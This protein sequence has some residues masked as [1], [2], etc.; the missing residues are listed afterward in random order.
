M[1]SRRLI[2]IIVPIY[3]ETENI[4]PIYQAVQKATKKLPY[5][6]E[7]IFVDDGS[8]DDSLQVLGGL[9]D[10]DK[11]VLVIE[12]VRNFGKEIAL[13]AGL[14]ASSGHAAIM[15]D[16]D[17][18]H[19]PEL[20]PEFIEK[21][22]GG[23][24]AVIGVRDGNHGRGWLMSALS[25]LFYKIVNRISDTAIVPNAT[26]FR[27]IDQIIIEEFNSFT[28]RNRLTRGLIDW[29]G[30]RHDQVYFTAPARFRGTASYSFTKLVR[31]A[32][33]G[34][35]SHSL[36]PLKLAGYIGGVI[37]LFSGPFGAFIFIERFVLND[38]LGLSFT[39]PA[40]LATL[41]LFL[42]GIVLACMGLMA[43]YIANIYDEVIN[44]P[45]YVVRTPRG[46]KVN[47]PSPR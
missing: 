5:D 18:Q 7:V 29:L 20:I 33:N 8:K 4:Q 2:S 6:F 11:K 3:N 19:P 44:R 25:K 21:W 36:F 35:V 14:H 43:L 40:I 27:L 31:L 1:A 22:E 15:L 13:T 41:I 30:F 39:G 42:V 38:P 24:E 16:A 28:E 26:D 17:L 12:L 46:R 45:L 47:R 32:I 34:L 37:I 10:K 9:R 23:A